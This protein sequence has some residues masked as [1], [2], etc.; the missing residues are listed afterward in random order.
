M[1][2]GFGPQSRLQCV[3]CR[4]WLL[5]GGSGRC[6]H[7]HR[8]AR[9]CHLQCQVEQVLCLT[10]MWPV[11]GL[12]GSGGYGPLDRLQ[13]VRCR[14][15]LPQGGSGICSHRHRA[16]RICHRPCQVEQVLCLTPMWPVSGLGGSG[17]SGPWD[18]LQ[19]VRCRS[20]LPQGGSG[21]CSHRHRAA[22]ICHRPCQ[23]E[24]SFRLMVMWPVSFLGP[25]LA[26]V[27]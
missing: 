11:S 2:V 9:V 12:G 6:S 17:G 16:A 25:V 7:R 8:A 5:Q 4:A 21:R 26:V 24:W 19:C 22:R 15:W 23:V 27:S 10:P 1:W 14:S 13:C 18:R 20:W 3:W